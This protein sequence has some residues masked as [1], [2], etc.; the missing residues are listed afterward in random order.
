MDAYVDMYQGVM[1]I[2]NLNGHRYV[3]SLLYWIGGERFARDRQ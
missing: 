3:L 2:I 1:G